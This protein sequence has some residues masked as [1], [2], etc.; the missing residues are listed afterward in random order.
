LTEDQTRSL[1][2]D[3]RGLP[4]CPPD[5]LGQGAPRKLED[6]ELA[7][8]ANQPPRC[9]VAPEPGRVFGVPAWTGKEE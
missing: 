4:P 6:S 1:V 3:P 2:T 9:A 8:L 7:D 5:L